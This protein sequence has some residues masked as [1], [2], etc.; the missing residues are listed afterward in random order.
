MNAGVAKLW[1]RVMTTAGV[2]Y[3]D[4]RV[5]SGGYRLAVAKRDKAIEVLVLGFDYAESLV[6]ADYAELMARFEDE[7]VYDEQG[8]EQKVS[9]QGRG[10]KRKSDG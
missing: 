10:R 8:Q 3:H 5:T 4:L 2:V 1:Q 9:K 6:D 7:V